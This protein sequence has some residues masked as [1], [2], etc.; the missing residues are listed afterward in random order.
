MAHYAF[1]RD[2]KVVQV[3]PGRD[4]TDLPDGIESWETYYGEKYGATC[5][6]TSYNT[7]QN[8]HLLGLE[9]FRGNFA[10]IGFTYDS[11]LDA[12]LPPKPFPSW[13]LDN[14]FAW[15]A[16][17]PKPAEGEW[18]WNEISK[19]WSEVNEVA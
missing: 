16:P 17:V 19:E 7:F 3:I 11:N 14:N 5:L 9:P 8:Q 12:F 6:R 13:Q 10:S 15:I 2:D 4:E 1:I 18:I